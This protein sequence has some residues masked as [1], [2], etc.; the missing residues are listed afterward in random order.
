MSAVGAEL[1][2]S[3]GRWFFLTAV[4]AELG[5]VDCSAF[6]LPVAFRKDLFSIVIL[7]RIVSDLIV[8]GE[9][10]EKEPGFFFISRVKIRLR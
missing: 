5:V 3:V 8:S 7:E 10:P 1:Y 4:R 9:R 2:L 6:T